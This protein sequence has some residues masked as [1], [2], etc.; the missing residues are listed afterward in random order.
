MGFTMPGYLSKRKT[1]RDKEN[2]WTYGS[3]KIVQG[4]KGRAKV[5]CR[6]WYVS[7]E[8]GNGDITLMEAD[9]LLVDLPFLV[10]NKG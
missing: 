6:C 9:T 10:S 5:L 7:G 8:N 1:W 4:D 2:N 3:L